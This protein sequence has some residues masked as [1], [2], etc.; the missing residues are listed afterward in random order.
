MVTMYETVHTPAAVRHW[1]TLLRTM[2]QQY[3]RV[4]AARGEPF[5]P[6]SDDEC[7]AAARLATDLGVLPDDALVGLQSGAPWDDAAC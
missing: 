7:A 3:A 1:V 4:A 6:L 5:S 2:E